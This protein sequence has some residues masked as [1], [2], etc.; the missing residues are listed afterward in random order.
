[1]PPRRP[2]SPLK[3]EP[4][5][6]NN[7]NGDDYPLMASDDEL[8]ESQLAA[9]HRRIEKLG[10]AYLKGQPLFILSA[11]LHGPLEKGWVN[12][13]KKDRRKAGATKRGNES[14][15]PKVIP[16]TSSRKRRQHQLQSNAYRS[17]SSDTPR[18]VSRSGSIR[19]DVSKVFS[20][21]GGA[22]LEPTTSSNQSPRFTQH[23]SGDA[24]WLKKDKVSTR[25]QNIDPPTSPTTSISSRHVRRAGSQFPGRPATPGYHSAKSSESEQAKQ[26][27]QHESSLKPEIALNA[28]A[29]EER[30]TPGSKLHKYSSQ[31]VNGGGSVQVVSSSSQLPKF[32]YRLK[33]A[34]ALANAENPPSPKP[35]E[36]SYCDAGVA[37]GDES[38][39]NESDEQP[40]SPLAPTNESQQAEP[41]SHQTAENSLTLTNASNTI[42]NASSTHPD[43]DPVHNP[44][45]GSTSENILPS[46]QHAPRNPA[47]SDNL[48]SLYSIAASKATSN[49]TED[50]NAD[51]QFS[52]QA[53]LMMAQRSFQNDLRS[54]EYSPASVRK[55]R[56]S[57]D[58][59]HQSPNAANITPFHKMNTPE[60]ELGKSRL[61]ST[62]TGKL[63]MISTQYILDAATPFTFSTEKK[64][65]FRTISPE[66]DRSK[67]KKRKT[68]SF[69]Q[70][71]PSE[72][73]SEH[74]TSDEDD[75]TNFLQ[76]QPAE[77]Q[78]SPST[79]HQSAF[80]LTLTGTTPPTAQ[81]G[82]GADSFNL[83]QAIAE[84]GSWLQQSFD[85][86]KDITHCQSA[87]IP[88]PNPADS[89]H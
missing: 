13:W 36:E 18:K 76:E 12:P 86:N 24:Q 43:N 75:T 31:S 87:Q 85:I 50:H 39:L 10:E 19:D 54:P 66:K 27:R 77:A 71:S 69:A 9:R 68:T 6:P 1:M 23:K 67:T 8:D 40:I 73:P 51:Q 61:G 15:E 34:K 37:D 44:K 59:N 74:F 20:T 84:A 16:E 17:Q 80:P 60:R 2:T 26:S 4:C 38:H 30:R 89:A 29:P 82:Q 48:T 56:A 78:M 55:R 33:H 35:V 45:D 88:N 49:R 70:S 25:F 14:V 72:I 53:A 57:Q 3:L 64:A 81:E 41:I 63:P 52:T 58:I 7:S 28:P 22:R 47:V 21:H 32:E 11:S 65:E 42:E 46:A 83:S 5:P 62:G 79:S